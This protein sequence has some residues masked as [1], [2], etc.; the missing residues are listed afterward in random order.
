VSG[1]AL[2]RRIDHLSVAVSSPEEVFTVLTAE[3]G[4]PALWSA[5][6]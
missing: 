4:L 3:L 2:V 6:A 1:D 5:A